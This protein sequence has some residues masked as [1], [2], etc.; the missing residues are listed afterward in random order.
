MASKFLSL[1]R[2]KQ[3]KIE[4]LSSQIAE[5]NREITRQY[6]FIA[7]HKDDFL[8][9]QIPHEGSISF[10]AQKQL[11]NVA[12]KQELNYLEYRLRELKEQEQ[13]LQEEM[14][15][16]R[17]ELEKYTILHQDEV[18]KALKIAK[19]KEADFLDEMGSVRFANNR[20][21]F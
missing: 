5:A 21:P 19:K 20:S 4:A 11:L 7:G 15:L 13:Q 8:T 2:I 17:I 16:A 10:F 12:F 6:E 14:R 18:Q 9:R 3:Q 1:V